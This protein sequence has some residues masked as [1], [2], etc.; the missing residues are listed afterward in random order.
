MF[1]VAGEVTFD[2]T[3][4]ILWEYDPV[5]GLDLPAGGSGGVSVGTAITTTDGIFK[6]VATVYSST[7]IVHTAVLEFDGR[8]ID[9]VW[10]KIDLD[11]GSGNDSV[12]AY[13]AMKGF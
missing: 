4:G 5:T 6:D 2:A 9:A 1:L 7:T 12:D 13:I 10:A 3:T 11:G 8:G